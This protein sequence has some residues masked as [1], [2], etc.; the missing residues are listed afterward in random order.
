MKNKRQDGDLINSLKLHKEHFVGDSK[1]ILSFSGKYRIKVNKFKPQT[2][3][4]Q[5]Y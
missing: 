1:W 3:V 4:S 5:L 2:E